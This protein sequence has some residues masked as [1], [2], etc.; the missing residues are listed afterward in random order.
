MLCSSEKREGNSEQ[1]RILFK[2]HLFHEFMMNDKTITILLISGLVYRARAVT[3]LC[4]ESLVS[5]R[6]RMENLHL[7]VVFQADFRRLEHHH[8]KLPVVARLVHGQCK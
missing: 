7:D 2:N 1:E 6:I 5:R 4:T 8:D 3:S